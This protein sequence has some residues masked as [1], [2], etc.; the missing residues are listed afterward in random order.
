MAQEAARLVRV[1]LQSAGVR[2]FV[3]LVG[4]IR[5]LVNSETLW[6]MC[7]VLDWYAHCVAR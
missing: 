6:D 1:V 4:P 7:S 2:V 3:L 5:S